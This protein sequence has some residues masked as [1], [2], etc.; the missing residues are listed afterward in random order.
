MAKAARGRCIVG[1]RRR[2]PAVSW[3]LRL[4]G[5]YDIERKFAKRGL[6][7]GADIHQSDSFLRRRARLGMRDRSKRSGNALVDQREHRLSHP[8]LDGV[9]VVTLS[10]RLPRRFA[11]GN[12]GVR[13]AS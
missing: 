5:E 2:V 6:S 11:R 8:A 12:R 9:N 13:R 1:R 3:R 10:M 7:G 4:R